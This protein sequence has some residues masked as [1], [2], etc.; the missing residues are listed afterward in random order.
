MDKKLLKYFFIAFIISL[1]LPLMWAM[2]FSDSNSALFVETSQFE[3]MSQEEISKLI[4]D[5][6]E[7][8]SLKD[9]VAATASAVIADV[10]AY[11]KA[12][13]ILYLI[14]FICVYFFVKIRGGH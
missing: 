13:F 9:H 10:P 5:R 8:I 12:S 7:K 6:S 14:M 4:K 2:L 1:I 3:G 11:L